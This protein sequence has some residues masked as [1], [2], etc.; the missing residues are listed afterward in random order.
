MAGLRR[1]SSGQYLILGRVLIEE[2]EWSV[3]ELV[4]EPDLVAQLD[5]FPTPARAAK[6]HAMLAN[7]PLCVRQ[8]RV[9]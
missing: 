8:S 3:V 2:P 4:D 5:A 1:V 9:R 7:P 6:L